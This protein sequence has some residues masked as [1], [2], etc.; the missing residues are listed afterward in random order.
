MRGETVSALQAQL[1][2]QQQAMADSAAQLEMQVMYGPAHCYIDDRWC[3]G[4]N[5]KR[6]LSLSSIRIKKQGIAVL[7]TH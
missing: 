4:A 1:N 7:R 6:E 5:G 2:Q 3:S